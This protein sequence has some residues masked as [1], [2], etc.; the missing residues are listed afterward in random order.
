MNTINM[1]G[2]ETGGKKLVSMLSI[3]LIA[4]AIFPLLVG[5]FF[6]LI[7]LSWLRGEPSLALYGLGDYTEEA[8]KI[9]ILFINGIYKIFFS[10]EGKTKLFISKQS[11]LPVI[12]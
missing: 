4:N 2:R 12:S 6:S 5:S 8:G 1:K 7:F 9:P 11:C 10:E 3:V